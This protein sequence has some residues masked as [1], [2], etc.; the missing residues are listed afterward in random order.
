MEVEV[1]L[2]QELHRPDH[3]Q[4][5]L[6]NPVTALIPWF[7]FAFLLEP[8]GFLRVSLLAF[9]LSLLLVGA[10]RLRGVRPKAFEISDSV[11][12]GLIVI[13]GVVH[14]PPSESWLSDH[15]DAVS[16]IALTLI[17]L[18]SLAI[19]RPFTAQYIDARFEG[20]DPDLLARLD[21]LATSI[22]IWALGLSSLVAAYGEW[23]LDQ[24]SNLWTSWIL[25]AVPLIAALELNLWIERRAIARAGGRPALAPPG[26]T[27]A[28]NLVVWLVPIGALSLVFDGAPPGLGWVLIAVGLVGTAIAQAGVIR[29]APATG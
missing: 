19:R 11:L 4:R 5:F 23:V 28:R 14:D 22:W 12:F 25:Q 7:V 2:D 29:S 9:G 10:A 20:A 21:W 1:D 3:L 17:A 24:Q 16:S 8:L 18:V 13:V 15:A 6:D 27:L 26:V